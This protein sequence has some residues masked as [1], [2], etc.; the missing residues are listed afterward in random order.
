M[1]SLKDLKGKVLYIDV[2]ATWCGPCIKEFP[3]LKK[4]I[5]DYKDKDIE[6]VS[7]S[8]DSKNQ[9]DKWRKMVADKNIGGLQLYDSEGLSSSFMRA[10]SVG[11][12][13]RF[14]MLDAEGK[15]ITARAPRPSSEEV[16]KF[17]DGH[18]EKPKVMK[19]KSS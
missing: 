16:R 9:Y 1:T 11:L 2:W 17:I 7:I 3:Y 18:L 4:L 12:I 6:F 8:I 15:I 19:F 5:E 10:F 13:P 14:M